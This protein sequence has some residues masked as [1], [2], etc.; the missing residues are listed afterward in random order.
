[1]DT[2]PPVFLIL[3]CICLGSLFL[4]STIKTAF[5]YAQKE[6][7]SLDSEILRFIAGKITK[8]SEKKIQVST[9]VSFAK[10]FFTALFVITIGEY[11]RTHH[12]LTALSA[13]GLTFLITLIILPICTYSIPRIIVYGNKNRFIVSSYFFYRII[14]II[15]LPFTSLMFI[16]N[17]LI[18][19]LRGYNKYFDFLT[20][21]EQQMLGDAGIN[22]T[23]LD[24]NEKQMIH[25]IFNF[26]KTSVQEIMIPR[27]D[28][29]ALEVNSTPEEALEKIS[30]MG[31][32]R[33]PVYEETIDKITGILYVKDI[34]AWLSAHGGD[35]PWSI[36]TLMRKPHFVPV[37][38]E[39]DDLMAD[40][41]TQ[42]SHMVVVVD[43][44]GG[45][46][47]LVTMEDILEEIVGE[48]HDEHDEHNEPLKKI[49]E[50]TYL[51]D[52]HIELD[53]LCERINQNINY[54]SDK[55][56]TLGGLVYY[57]LGDVPK[58]NTQFRYE[59][60]Q[61]KIT[62]MDKQRIEEIKLE[63]QSDTQETTME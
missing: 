57:E 29:E 21:E 51:A 1:L 53:D 60:M 3:L 28:I 44:Y 6:L 25:N 7:L 61:I 31:H 18:S 54:K 14:S 37:N 59:A 47:G 43:E 39:L 42:R 11:I 12:A 36:K 15:F 23:G 50:S 17:L 19:K 35:T 22:E 62:K 10:T 2:S 46:A 33:V 13:A 8:L 56:N 20:E 16:S 26:D 58:Q 55:Y 5:A 63:I 45:T 30:T 4:L 40:M 38:K 41:K 52:P 24:E 49:G 27:I 34:M 9:T 48:I 32:S